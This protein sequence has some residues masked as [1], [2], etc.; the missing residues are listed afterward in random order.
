MNVKRISCIIPFWNE[1]L[2][3][4]NVLDQV[5]KAGNIDEIICVDDASDNENYR[6]VRKKYPHIRLIRLSENVGKTDAI[7]E[8]LK[9]AGGHYI[10]LLDADLQNLNHKDLEKA[11]RAVYKN[12]SIDM[13]I[14]RRVNADLLI[15]MYRADVLFTGERILKKSDLIEILDGPVKRWQLESAIN[16]WM[17]LNKK[18]V[19]WIPQSAINTDKS[20]KWGMLNGLI[21][22]IRTFGDMMFATGLNNFFKQILFYAKDELKF[23]NQ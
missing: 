9:V 16:T 4:F 17:Y 21:Y 3:L 7:R 23:T 14:L 15:R 1:G 10:L 18:K 20:L 2:F 22:D 5:S 11:V 6:T 8:G 19:F 13:L 12:P